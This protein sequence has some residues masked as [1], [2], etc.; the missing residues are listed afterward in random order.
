[1]DVLADCLAASHGCDHR[2]AEVLRVRAREADSLDPVDRVARAKQLAELRGHV[3]REVAAPRVHVLAEQGDLTHAVAGELLD[4]GDDVAWASALL[5]AAHGRDDAVGA[6]R[7]AAHRHLHPRL[8]GAFTMCRQMPCEVIV[9]AE[10][11]ARNADATCTDPVGEM[12]DRP[13]PEGDVDE[14]VLLEDSLAL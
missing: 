11:A 13:R 7:V 3:R 1:M 10:A 9:R 6:L 12:R 4:L 5:A 2:R 8:K 14:G